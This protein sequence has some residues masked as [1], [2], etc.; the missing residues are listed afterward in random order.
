MPTQTY[1]LDKE[2]QL[3]IVIER[4]LDLTI[5]NRY[6]QNLPDLL[7]SVAG[8]ALFLYF[9]LGFLLSLWNCNYMER[10]M[11]SQ[12]YRASWDDEDTDPKKQ[13]GKSEELTA[14]ECGL[15]HSLSSCISCL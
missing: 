2:T 10:Y 6:V 3:D 13:A 12:L 11:V 9:F 8:V 5:I 15:W 4:D 14:S 7:A 1:E